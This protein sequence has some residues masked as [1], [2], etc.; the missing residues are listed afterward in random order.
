MGFGIGLGFGFGSQ[1]AAGGGGVEPIPL[2]IS[3]LVIN[4]A[5]DPDE[6]TLTANGEGDLYW[7]VTASATTPTDIQ[8]IAGQDHTGSAATLSDS[9]AVAIGETVDNPD[10][11]ALTAGT[12]Y[13]HCVLDG[14]SEISNTLTS[15][16]FTIAAS[17]T[18][19][20]QQFSGTAWLERNSDVTG[21]PTNSAGVTVAFTYQPS[22]GNIGVQVSLLTTLP[23]TNRLFEIV[24]LSTNNIR[25]RTEN[26]SD[27]QTYS[28]TASGTAMVAGTKYL[29]L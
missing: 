25:A 22:A 9:F 18:P 3:D 21:A 8:I 19:A 23:A 26:S 14:I 28:I 29:V 24:K 1:R 13:L 17:F 12:W 16:S 2:A 27:A 5:A 6:I 7:V 4:T 15:S 10:F 20:W 11:S